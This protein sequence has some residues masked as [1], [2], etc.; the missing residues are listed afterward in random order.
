MILAQY[1][2]MY[3]RIIIHRDY[4]TPTTIAFVYN[5]DTLT[6]ARFVLAT[7][8]ILFRVAVQYCNE[9]TCLRKCRGTRKL[10]IV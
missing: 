4:V 8:D 1:Y 2:R 7:R 6:K 9:Q 10:D 3:R 5:G